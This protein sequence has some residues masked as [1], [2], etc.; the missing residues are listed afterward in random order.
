MRALGLALFALTLP[1]C[2][3]TCPRAAAP[4]PLDSAAAERDVARELD[5]FHDAAAHADEARYFAHFAAEG[6]FLGTDVTE[7]WDVPAFRAY[8]H[9]HFASGKG[10]TY[11]PVRRAVA[12]SADG[13]TAW[14]DEDL[15]GERAGPTRGVGTMVR[16]D[17]RWLVAVYGLSF[18]IPNERFEAVRAALAGSGK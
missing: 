13:A 10:W 8:A 5:D 2:A 3:S 4:A 12:I 18:T 11:H 1:A 6:V 7:R 9:P 17:G 16:R 15:N 14:F